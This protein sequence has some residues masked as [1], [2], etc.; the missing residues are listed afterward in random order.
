MKNILGNKKDLEFYNKDGVMVYEF[1]TL[2]DDSYS[3]EY[4]YDKNGNLLTGK[5][6]DD[7]WSKYTYDNKG[8][9]LTY[10]NSNGTKRGFEIQEFTME[11][12]VKEL[13][14]FKLIK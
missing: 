13:G 1:C 10:E 8:N 11:E 7:Y 3:Y 6:S 12:L 4:I 2:S 14:N 9:E 5:Y